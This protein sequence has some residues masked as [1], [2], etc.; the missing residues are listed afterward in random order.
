MAV[1]PFFPL[2]PDSLLFGRYKVSFKLP[3]AQSKIAKGIGLTA[4]GGL[5][6]PNVEYLTKFIEGNVGIGEG[7]IK[8]ML[9]QNFSSPVA[10]SNPKVFK[11]FARLSKIDIPDV[12]KYKKPDGKLSLPQ[13][14]LTISK[15]W[16]STGVIAFEKTTLKSI[17]ETQK[18]YIEVAKLAISSIAKI[19]DI[20]ARVMPLVSASP[21][22]TRSARPSSN[23]NAVGFQ[24]GK[25]L[26]TNLSKLE[27]LAAKGGTVSVNKE[28]VAIRNPKGASFS[29]KNN[30]NLS[31]NTSGSWEIISTVYSTGVFKPD[32]EY[33]YKYINLP[34]EPETP[35]IETQLDLSLEDPYDKY[36]PK[37]LIFGIFDSKGVPLNP[38]SKLDAILPSGLRGESPYFKAD[39][40]VD[41]EKWKFPFNKNNPTGNYLWPVFGT[42]FFRWK[43]YPGETKESKTQP[44]SSDPHPDWELKKYKKGEKNIINGLDAIE[45]D[46]IIT[47]F[48]PSE[49]SEY[50]SLFQD[51]AR[52]KFEKSDL[53]EQEKSQYLSQVLSQVDVR[54]HLETVFLYGQTGKSV[55]KQIN[56]PGLN[57]NN[58]FPDEMKKSWKPYKITSPE[59]GQDPV[60]KK[61]FGS[62]ANQVWVDPESDYYTKVIRVDPTTKI[63]YKQ[64]NTG[65]DITAEIKSFVKNMTIIKLEDNSPFNISVRKSI[66]G[67]N[68]N[69]FYQ[70]QDLTQYP[71]ENWNFNDD[72]GVLANEIRNEQDVLTF[73]NNPPILSNTNKYRVT[74]WNSKPTPYYENKGYVAWSI[75]NM[76]LATREYV[77]IIKKGEYFTYNKFKFNFADRADYSLTKL[78]EKIETGSSPIEL[79]T[80]FEKYNQ[81]PSSTY[82]F[83][84]TTIQNDGFWVDRTNKGHI[85]G[86]YM[87][88]DNSAN[89]QEGTTQSAHLIIKEKVE[90]ESRTMKDIRDITFA[91]KYATHIIVKQG[92]DTDKKTYRF[93]LIQ[94]KQDYFRK[95]T[96]DPLRTRIFID[97]LS[98]ESFEN[99]GFK[100]ILP[101]NV[102]K[103][104]SS[105][106]SVTNIN[107]LRFAIT[108]II[109][110]IPL[111][112]IFGEL[113]RQN[114]P[115]EGLVELEEDGSIVEV[116]KTGKI[117]K[118]YYMLPGSTKTKNT[119]SS[120]SNGDLSGT[121]TSQNLTS[122]TELKVGTSGSFTNKVLPE[123][124]VTRTISVMAQRIVGNT[125]TGLIKGSTRKPVQTGIDVNMPAF[126][127]RVRNDDGS[128]SIIDPTK[129]LNEQ[130]RVA[131]PFSK[132]K[133]GHGSS[134][135]PQ[136]IEVIKR[137]MLTEFDTESYYIIEGIRPDEVAKLSPTAPAAGGGGGDDY[138]LPDAVGAI[139]IFVM[140]LVDIFSKLFPTIM[141]LIKLFQNPPS[142]VSDIIIEKLEENFTF[143]GKSAQEVFKQAAKMKESIPSVNSAKKPNPSTSPTVGLDPNFTDRTASPKANIDIKQL[144]PALTSQSDEINKIKKQ[145]AELSGL[146]KESELSN[147]VYVA[148]D[149]KLVSVLDGVSEIPFGVFGNDLPAPVTGQGLPKMKLPFGLKLQ[150]GSLPN[151]APIGLI[152]NGDIK[153]NDFNTIENKI[154]GVN[155][156]DQQTPIKSSDLSQ[157]PP[158]T[159]NQPNTNTL[160]QTNPAGLAPDETK[161]RFEDGSSVLLKNTQ[162]NDFI[163]NNSSKYNF[164]Y[165]QEETAAQIREADSL[166]EFGT[167]DDIMKA[168]ELL[169]NA[170]KNEPGNQA[171]QD[172]LD[173]AKKLKEKIESGQQPLLKIILGFVTLPIKIIS[174]IVEYI[175]AFFKSLTNPLKL[176]SAMASFL[177]FSWVVDLLKPTGLL[178]LSGIK[179]KP[180]K[181][182]EWAALSFIPNPLNKEISK[183]LTLPPDIITKGF[184][185]KKPDT[186]GYLFKDDFKI[187][188]MSEYMNAAF[189]VK[190]PQVSTLQN[191]Q[192]PFL[193]MRTFG[194]T[195]CLLEKI[196]NSII[197]FIWSTLGI[198]AVIPPPYIKLCKKLEEPKSK[199]AQANIDSASSQLSAFDPEKANE[200]F[201]GQGDSSDPNSGLR[202]FIYEVKLPNGETK[203]FL[204]RQLLDEFI[205]NNKGLNYEF[206][207]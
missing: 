56:I 198:E 137:F 92:S 190:L 64:A 110:E 83:E 116:D 22:T 184:N 112:D 153:K 196:I 58:P 169:D 193:Y 55:Y 5:L 138:R 143:L 195:L 51:I 98:I 182:P 103:K 84:Q 62:N 54:A 199:D 30:G 47:K 186:G 207:F 166:I 39:W 17:F 126:Q 21:L 177:S 52:I 87:N 157:K 29:G 69:D 88:K 155:L 183:D 173:A 79:E 133:Y 36:K 119:N 156:G 49:E 60:F 71:L 38:L 68:F 120:Y 127:I 53:T 105:S 3:L 59:A 77:E 122:V 27:S 152:F 179:F 167:I 8:G 20:V 181:L 18:P 146:V 125:K 109:Y 44:G 106:G 130:L 174:G 132:G 149:G 9:S 123:N 206:N 48:E 111:K 66:D 203:E 34:P 114:I 12:N 81:N 4:S 191:R 205:E 165:V 144:S 23:P 171:V 95:T 80:L 158:G 172:K 194:P 150:M 187:A 63:T 161:I 75:P 2:Y 189:N 37:Q 24:N 94:N 168:V 31:E 70:G 13:S 160:G 147:Y 129:I 10:S 202:E 154:K 151:K 192:G 25:E 176:P 96:T 19:E 135:D 74:L 118:W 93:K 188:D 104:I 142:F 108:T 73:K 1:P 35:E 180:E 170:A 162:A 107:P 131:Q 121:G 41:S 102:F 40:I 50:R 6:I 86:Y 201:S 175:L 43:R 163:K 140:L 42:P 82:R 61:L 159:S 136:E 141:K 197:D 99:G 204:N 7:L 128:L 16:E 33:I 113:K 72:D 89:W 45:G 145:V 115:V 134:D 65:K 164:V 28:G 32:V 124:N 91:F 26:A 85:H 46:P 185:P 11:E 101:K 148:D 200:L 100:S 67:V 76:P 14:E 139:K 78:K 178:S 15:E 90:I 57:K 117:S 97:E